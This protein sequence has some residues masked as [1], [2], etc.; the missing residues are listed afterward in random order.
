MKSKIMM[1]KLDSIKRKA[2]DYLPI[3]GGSMIFSIVIYSLLMSEQL[4]NHFDGLW[5]YSYYFAG[6]WEISLGRWLWPYLDRLRSGISIDPTTSLLTLMCFSAGLILLLDIFEIEKRIDS[7]LICSLFLSNVVVCVSLSYRYMS[8]TFGLAFLLS[9]LAVWITVKIKKTHI[10]VLLGALSTAFSLG[11]YQAYLGCTC[12][13]AFGYFL[14]ILSGEEYTIRTVLQKVIRCVSTIFSGGVLYFILLNLIMKIKHIELSS[15]RGANNISF[16]N[17]FLELPNTIVKTYQEFLN[18]FSGKNIKTIL[19]LGGKISAGK[20]YLFLFLL[21]LCLLICEII[22]LWKKER[23]RAVLYIGIVLLMPIA[24]NVILLIVTETY[25]SIQMAAPLALCIPTLLCV[26]SKMKCFN[27]FINIYKYF[28][29]FIAAIVIYGC[30]GQVMID[31]NA[32]QE[33]EVATITIAEEVI[34]RLDDRGVLNS[35]ITY[36]LVGRPSE[37]GLFTTS[38]GFNM[39]NSY[40]RFGRWGMNADGMTKGWRGVFSHLCRINLKICSVATYNEVINEE[41]VKD[42]PVFPAEGSIFV[43]DDIVIIRIAE[44]Y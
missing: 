15:Y 44:N 6:N 7:Y 30:T 26:L 38:S 37:N 25:I 13:A 9:I 35:D 5:H 2:K 20:I 17:M 14:F 24:C 29:F 28:I 40:A 41:D 31:Q 22:R 33:G 42:M 12:V 3:F 1:L 16:I 8:V 39:A 34:H 36:C 19:L 4:V 11:L 32:M 23:I 27:I 10:A 43:K 21:I 18:F